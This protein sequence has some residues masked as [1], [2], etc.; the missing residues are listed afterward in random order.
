MG[1]DMVDEGRVA[2]LEKQ[3]A[4]HEAVCG[5]RY[6]SINFKLNVTV[7][8]IGIILTAISAGDPLVAFLRRVVGG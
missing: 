1:G 3:F 7:A 2:T 5:E 6:K 4:V 8:G